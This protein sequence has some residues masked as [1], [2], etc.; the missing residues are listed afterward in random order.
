[1]RNLQLNV[2]LCSF[3]HTWTYFL[4]HKES[5]TKHLSLLFIVFDIILVYIFKMEE[6]AGRKT[7]YFIYLKIFFSGPL[8]PAADTAQISGR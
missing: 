6:T 5:L 7:I 2:F 1:V 3:A 4:S 8:L